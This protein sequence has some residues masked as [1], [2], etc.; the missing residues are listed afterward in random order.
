[1][2]EPLG[3][4]RDHIKILISWV[5]ECTRCEGLFI[6]FLEGFVGGRRG[7]GVRGWS[8]V[9]TGS[10]YR[11]RC[12]DPLLPALWGMMCPSRTNSRMNTEGSDSEANSREKGCKQITRRRKK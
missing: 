8:H 11:Q 3:G 4:S 10:T 1:M 6:D 2:F 5:L 12:A 7:E 9:S